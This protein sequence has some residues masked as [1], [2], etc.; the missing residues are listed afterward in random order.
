[1]LKKDLHKVMSLVSYHYHDRYGFTYPHVKKILTSLLEK[2]GHF[3]V[4]LKNISLSVAESKTEV[5]L[6]LKLKTTTDKRETYL[7]G[8]EQL[9]ETVVLILDRENLDWK[10]VEVYFPGQDGIGL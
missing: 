10:V 8:S 9:H 1:M 7:L 4:E 6:L 5:R 2:N 3:V